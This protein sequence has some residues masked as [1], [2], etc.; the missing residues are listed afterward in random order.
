[1]K[2]ESHPSGPPCE[3]CKQAEKECNTIRKSFLI[4]MVF[5]NSYMWILN[6]ASIKIIVDLTSHNMEELLSESVERILYTANRASTLAFHVESGLL[7][8]GFYSQG[9]NKHDHKNDSREPESQHLD[10]RQSYC[11]RK[12]IYRVS[13]WIGGGLFFVFIFLGIGSFLTRP[14]E[15]D[16]HYAVTVAIGLIFLII[17]GIT[18]STTLSFYNK[19]SPAQGTTSTSNEQNDNRWKD[20]IEYMA[21][22]NVGDLRILL[23]Y[24]ICA[25]S[26]H[27]LLTLKVTFGG[28]HVDVYQPV[29]EALKGLACVSLTVFMLWLSRKDRKLRCW[30]KLNLMLG[31]VIALICLEL[32]EE[33]FEHSFAHKD[34][35]K[36]YALPLAIDFKTYVFVHSY[37][38]VVSERRK[39]KHS[40]ASTA[41]F[42]RPINI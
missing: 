11:C 3:N 27:L 22:E 41:S 10:E 28:I 21:G 1:M 24:S 30:F 7:F 5:M 29:R 39:I 2:S 8:Y 20:L 12:H 14:N 32:I 36:L 40:N 37:T 17:I 33:T 35:L 9:S 42:N 16:V 18:L 19:C 23:F 25:V 38:H 34:P 13:R 31:N 26:Y 4:M 15:S 6:V